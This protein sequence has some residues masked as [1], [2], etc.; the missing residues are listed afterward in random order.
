MPAAHK[1]SGGASTA[2]ISAIS[3]KVGEAANVSQPALSFVAVRIAAMDLLL[4]LDRFAKYKQ[5]RTR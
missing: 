4:F 5:A 1:A 3:A 2:V